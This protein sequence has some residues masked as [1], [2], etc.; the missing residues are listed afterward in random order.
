[1]ANELLD[2]IHAQLGA[3][4]LNETILEKSW[5]ELGQTLLLVRDTEEWQA[6]GFE[7][8]AQFMMGLREKY[9]RGKTQLWNYLTV[10]E[11]LLPTISALALEDM[12]ISKAIELKRALRKTGKAIPTEIVQAATNSA[13][14]AGDIRK[15][16]G[17]AFN[18]APDDKSKWYDLDGIFMTV[19]ERE[20]FKETVLL[21]KAEMDIS[22]AT[23]EHVRRK[24]VWF[25]WMQEY[26][27][28]HLP[29]QNAPEEKQN[30]PATLLLPAHGT[31]P[32]SG[33]EQPEFDPDAKPGTITEDCNLEWQQ[34]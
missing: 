24:M 9:K 8:F 21:T 27:A 14:S 32:T 10:A 12:G 2:K 34:Q 17:N 33:M 5:M 31:V 13:T 22:P 25:A 20:E 4:V 7:S 29:E 28:T 3:A 15:L 11:S 26:R 18:I 6:A 30:T 19:E 16:L 23:P 1:M